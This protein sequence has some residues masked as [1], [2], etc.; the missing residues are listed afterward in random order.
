MGDVNLRSKLANHNESGVITNI[1]LKTASGSWATRA[2]FT[3]TTS[4]NPVFLGLHPGPSTDGYVRLL[5]LGVRG[6]WRILRDGS[7]IRIGLVGE[8][9]AF[10]DIYSGP[11]AFNC[12]DF[13]CPAGNHTFEFQ[14][15]NSGAS[16]GTTIISC[17]FFGIELS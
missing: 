3:L 12:W 16:V 14:G 17:S 5:N 10:A 7:V 9:S 1:D 2:S 4:G 13:G 8:F 11:G 15:G 6:D